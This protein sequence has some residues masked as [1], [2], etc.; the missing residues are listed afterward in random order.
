MKTRRQ[1]DTGVLRTAASMVLALAFTLPAAARAD[2]LAGFQPGSLAQ[3]EQALEQGEPERAL[4]LLHR[5]RAILR[6][7]RFR[8]QA[9]ALSCQA[10]R[11]L[12]DTRNAAR[13]CDAVVAYDSKVVTTVVTTQALDP[14]AD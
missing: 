4:S 6:H 7:S 3:A 8:A 9:E 2:S 14:A 13:A 11:Q 12:G 1:W 10:Y 5:Q